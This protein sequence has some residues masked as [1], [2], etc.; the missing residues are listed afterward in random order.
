MINSNDEILI[1]EVR[2][3]EIILR[4]RSSSLAVRKMF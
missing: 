2:N 1:E 4:Y 3:F